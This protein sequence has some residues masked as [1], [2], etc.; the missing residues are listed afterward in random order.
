MSNCIGVIAEDNS[1]VEVVNEIIKKIAP[2]KRYSIK[3]FVGHGCGKIQGKCFQ[4]AGVLKTKGCS[5]LIM[6]H[7]LDDRLLDELDTSL[8]QTLKNCTIPKHIVVIPVKEIEAWLLTD[9]LAI[10]RAFKL[11][12]KVERISNPEII[13]DPKRKLDEIVRLR[14][15]STK[16]YINSVHN[17][18]IAAE[19]ELVNLRRCSSFRPLENFLIQNLK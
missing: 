9:N 10:Q 3:S 2:N 17:Q 14:S 19:I 5:L 11:N 15:G 1:D 7:D 8:R 16:R 6:L 18:K 12:K 4:W 13:A